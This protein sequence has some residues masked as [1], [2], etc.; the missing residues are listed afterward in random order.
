MNFINLSLSSVLIL[1][2]STLLLFSFDPISKIIPRLAD[3]LTVIQTFFTFLGFVV[4]LTGV[5]EYIKRVN[6]KSPPPP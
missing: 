3:K 2:I 4:A 6:K 1:E 5:A